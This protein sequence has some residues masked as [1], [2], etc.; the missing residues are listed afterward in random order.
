MEAELLVM[1][2]AVIAKD[3]VT[4]ERSWNGYFKYKRDL[5]IVEGRIK[6]V[7]SKRQYLR[8]LTYKMEFLR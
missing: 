5:D 7:G 8:Y 6:V 4:Y 1:E 2:C 3:P